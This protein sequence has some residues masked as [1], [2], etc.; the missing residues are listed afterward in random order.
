MTNSV[1]ILP[2]PQ[3]A[4]MAAVIEQN[5]AIEPDVQSRGIHRADA[6]IIEPDGRQLWV[7]VKVISTKPKVGIQHALCQTEVAK[8]KQYE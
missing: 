6:R 3:P 8:C 7:D 1:I 2:L 4:G 5:M